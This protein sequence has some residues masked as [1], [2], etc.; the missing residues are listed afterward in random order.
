MKK[1]YLQHGDALLAGSEEALTHFHLDTD[2]ADSEQEALILA[3]RFRRRA[4][5]T[6][7][8]RLEFLM[9]KI[10]QGNFKRCEVGEDLSIE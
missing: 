6:A 8:E 10:I 7:L 5:E 1:Y 4:V 2:L 3:I 9:A